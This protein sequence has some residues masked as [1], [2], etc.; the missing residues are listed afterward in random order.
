MSAVE[1]GYAADGTTEE[2]FSNGLR[3]A[4]EIW[5]LADD[6]HREGGLAWEIEAVR[7][8][9]QLKWS[10]DVA[11]AAYAARTDANHHLPKER[12][13]DGY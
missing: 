10:I 2:Q 11:K 3:I 4:Q 5:A 1:V 8:Q 9:E 13:Q 7:L 6:L 12:N